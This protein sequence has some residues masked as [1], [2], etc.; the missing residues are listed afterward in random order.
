MNFEFPD[1]PYGLE[2]QFYQEDIR[3]YKDNKLFSKLINIFEDDY[4]FISVSLIID[5]LD[6]LP[7]IRLTVRYTNAEVSARCDLC[8]KDIEVAL[9]ICGSCSDRVYGVQ[10][11]MCEYLSWLSRHIDEDDKSKKIKQE[12]TSSKKKSTAEKKSKKK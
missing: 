6:C 1:I 12:H 3:N 8:S 2:L 5:K 4:C 7:Y 10:K 11:D 9:A